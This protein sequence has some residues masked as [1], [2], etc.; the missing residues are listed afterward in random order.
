MITLFYCVG[1]LVLCII[2]LIVIGSRSPVRIYPLL[3]WIYEHLFWLWPA[4]PFLELRFWQYKEEIGDRANQQVLQN[5]STKDGISLSNGDTQLHMRNSNALN[6]DKT[7]SIQS[8]RLRASGGDPRSSYL[9]VDKKIIEGIEEEEEKKSDNNKMIKPPPLG[10]EDIPNE[11]VPERSPFCV[12]D[13]TRK[14][15]VRVYFKHLTD[16]DYDALGSVEWQEG[17]AHRK[18]KRFVGFF[19]DCQYAAEVQHITWKLVRMDDRSERAEGLI[20]VMPG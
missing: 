1:V 14:T 13:C 9:K 15:A 16:D 6:P 4:S 2:T 17:S 19:Q 5:L 12:R 8:R 10:V 7:E 3:D 18:H 11:E 20:C